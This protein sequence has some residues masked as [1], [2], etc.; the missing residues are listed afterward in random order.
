M[1]KQHDAKQPDEHQTHDTVQRDGCNQHDSNAQEHDGITL[2][3]SFVSQHA[4]RRY[5]HDVEQHNVHQQHTIERR[6]GLHPTG[7]GASHR[8][9][10]QQHVSDIHVCHMQ[11]EWRHDTGRHLDVQYH[12][13]RGHHDYDIQ[14]WHELCVRRASHPSDRHRDAGQCH[15]IV[16]H[17]WHAQC[18]EHHVIGHD[19]D[20]AIHQCYERSDECH[21]LDTS[22]T[23]TRD[24]STQQLDDG[25]HERDGQSVEHHAPEQHRGSDIH[26]WREQR[27]ARNVPEKLH[28]KDSQEWDRRLGDHRGARQHHDT[29]E[30]HEQHDDEDRAT[31]QQDAGIAAA[32]QAQRRADAWLRIV[33]PQPACDVQ[34]T[35]AAGNATE[36]SGTTWSGTAVRIV[37]DYTPAQE[38]NTATSSGDVVERAA[39]PQLKR[40]AADRC[41]PPC[42]T[43]AGA[44]RHPRQRVAGA[45][46]ALALLHLLAPLLGAFATPPRAGAGGSALRAGAKA[47]SAAAQRVEELKALSMEA[48]M[49]ADED[50]PEDTARCQELAYELQ[51][52]EARALKERADEGDAPLSALDSDSY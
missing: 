2:R 16:I 17:V 4:A 12:D 18:E 42:A 34:F 8:V 47:P 46:V 31:Q 30:W 21:V 39:L 29:D 15:E 1:Y 3:A 26:E 37:A 38:D 51:E 49:I 41:S 45:A 10:E 40:P 43:M 24:A 28:D 36:S 52:A 7:T 6:D 19:T 13:A 11:S 32:W 23:F 35:T 48:C 22:R 14:A 33:P 44:R 9:T 5:D 25:I 27:D 20:S 50:N